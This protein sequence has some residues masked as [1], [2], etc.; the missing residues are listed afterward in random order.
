MYFLNSFDCYWV[1]KDWI[2]QHDCNFDD[3]SKICYSRSHLNKGILE[4]RLF[5]PNEFC[6]PSSLLYHLKFKFTSIKQKLKSKAKDE[7]GWNW[8]I[9]C[10]ILWWKFY[11]LKRPPWLLMTYFRNTIHACAKNLCKNKNHINALQ[12][13]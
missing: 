7:C 8:K 6:S 3:V 4:W 10:K 2:K 13:T 12:A 9:D 5:L 11:D 1:F